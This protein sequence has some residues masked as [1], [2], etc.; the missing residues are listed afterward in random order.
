MTAELFKSRAGI[1]M[2]HVPYKGS[3]P[4]MTDLLG[5]Q[6]PLMF[7]SL[8]AALGQIR[9]GRVKMLAVTTQS[10]VPQLPDVPTVAESGYAGFEGVGWSGIVLPKNVAPELVE[11]I[12]ADI[13]R[14]LNEPKVRELILER[15]SIPDPRT[16]QQ[17]ARF[18]QDEIEKW[19]K[20][21]RTANVKLD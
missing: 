3:G 18:I 12:S 5:G 21:A 4:A 19:G 8:S 7:D 6:V 15:G 17:Y 20:V 13:R 16:P 9:G 11:R 14:V 10:R 1:D 2:L